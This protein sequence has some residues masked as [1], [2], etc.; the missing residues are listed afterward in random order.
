MDRLKKLV[1]KK[2]KTDDNPVPTK[3]TRSNLMKYY[4]KGQENK[5]ERTPL[6]KQI[7]KKI[8]K[9][10]NLVPKGG[11]LLG[12]KKKNKIYSAD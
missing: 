1:T 6:K 4:K 12:K 5:A 9:V 11:I 10:G 8:N 2:K 3:R 7:T